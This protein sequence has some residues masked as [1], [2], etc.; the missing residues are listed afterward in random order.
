MDK[1]DIV[2]IEKIRQTVI[3]HFKGL[4]GKRMSSVVCGGA[5]SS[6]AVM[7]FLRECFGAIVDE[8][9]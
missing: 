3:K 9:N 4:L 5:P 1:P 8:G 2:E 7:E 6:K